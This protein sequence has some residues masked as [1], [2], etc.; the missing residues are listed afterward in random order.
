MLKSI[1]S[2]FKRKVFPNLLTTL[3]EY[4]HHLILEKEPK[5]VGVTGS[6]GK[7][8]FLHML[9]TVMRDE[10]KTKTTFNGNSET[11]LPLEILGIR[12]VLK[13]YSIFNW[14]MIFAITPFA[15]LLRKVTFDYEL[16]IAEM[17]IDSSKPPKNMSYLLEIIK[18]E[19]GILLSISTAH[20]QQ[21]AQE[22]QLN[23]NDTSKI[24]QAIADEKGKIVTQLNQ[25]AHAIINID[26]PFI[27]NL[28]PQIK[29]NL[30]TFGTSKDADYQLLTHRVS[31]SESTF[32]VA[33]DGKKHTI[34]IPN[35]MLSQE[36]GL[37]ILATLATSRVLG[38]SES[39]AIQTLEK[40]LSLPPGRMS[41]IDG[42]NKS[43]ILDSSY[44]SSPAALTSIL[45]TTKKVQTNGKK[46]FVLG[47]MR[48]LG[49][50]EKNA[51]EAIYQQ[52]KDFADIVILVGPLMEKYLAPKLAQENNIQLHTFKQ[53]KGVGE[54]MLANDLVEEND[55]ITI[56]GSQNTIFL[57]Q[58]VYE[59]MADQK[60]A[61]SR[62]CRQ[63]KY[64]IEIKSKFFAQSS[65]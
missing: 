1:E 53:S 48:E 37:L 55:L 49:P 4:S 59:L 16:L 21:F 32:Q 60:T 13:D 33:F 47:D 39:E 45:E 14:L 5:I 7:S 15:Y 20:S 46:I 8:S 41:L 6:V 35:H 26:S 27:T 64:W 24:L 65:S 34:T 28:I 2:T 40:K 61:S 38:V 50:L 62:L 23:Q 44:N 10:M 17:G 57:E 11:G 19:I 3:K 31:L 30:I 29:A 56:K 36:Y 43:T 9:D 22:L 25:E 12:D 63:S 54:F 52:I 51:H 18:P 42:K 58:V